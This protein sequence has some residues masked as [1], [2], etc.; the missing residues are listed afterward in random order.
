MLKCI[1]HK[2]KEEAYMAVEYITITIPKGGRPRKINKSD[3]D[4]IRT[5]IDNGTDMAD[6]A[7][8]Y[9]VSVTTMYRTAR[10]ARLAY[11]EER[12]RPQATES[13]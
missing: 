4:D 12:D 1:Y 9:N 5:A 7:K 2:R 10:K 3:Y 8:Q 13:K 11:A 6:L